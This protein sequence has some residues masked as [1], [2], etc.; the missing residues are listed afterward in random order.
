MFLASGRRES[1]FPLIVCGGGGGGNSVTWCFPHCLHVLS[2]AKLLLFLCPVPVHIT[3]IQ[4]I[5]RQTQKDRRPSTAAF[6]ACWAM[7]TKELKEYTVKE[8]TV[9]ITNLTFRIYRKVHSFIPHSHESSQLH[10]AFTRK[11]TASFSIYRKVHSFIPHLLE[12]PQLHSAFAG[13]FP[14]SFSSFTGKSTTS[15]PV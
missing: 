11:F 2:V 12:I 9:H 7:G 3:V 15:Y 1:F 8:C 6:L 13:K 10:S 4:D 14:A 5:Q